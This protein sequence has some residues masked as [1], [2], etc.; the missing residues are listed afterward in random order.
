[1][2]GPPESAFSILMDWLNLMLA[3]LHSQLRSAAV[4]HEKM[5]GKS[6]NC[7]L[8]WAK[9]DGGN[10]QS[11]V[12]LT[13]EHSGSTHLSPSAAGLAGFIKQLPESVQKEIKDALSGL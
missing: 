7:V 3:D 2:L 11:G 4:R 1:M 13:M 9:M 6:N 8:L 10:V 5:V 12:F